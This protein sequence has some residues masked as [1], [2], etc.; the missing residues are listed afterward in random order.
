M[1]CYFY[2]LDINQGDINDATGNFSQPDYTVF[3]NYTDCNGDPQT[4]SF[5][6][7]GFYP[8]EICV[9]ELSIPF[10]YYYKNDSPSLAMFSTSSQE[11]LC[12]AGEAPTP[13]PTFVPPTPTPTPT[14]DGTCWTIK[15]A[16]GLDCNPC[17]E[18]ND[19][20]NQLYISWT[21][22]SGVYHYE[23]WNDLMYDPFI[24]EGYNTYYLCLQNSTSPGYLG[25]SIV[26]RFIYAI[27]SPISM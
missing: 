20:I 21:D 22:N 3:V 17:N 23:E 26:S 2:S 18:T 8:N 5:G 1:D 13:T 15:I 7:A 16:N 6:L 11:G 12:S 19:G 27:F 14:N 24:Y 25:Y 9:Q 10:I 4:T